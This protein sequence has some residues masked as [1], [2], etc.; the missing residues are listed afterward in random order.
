MTGSTERSS[1]LRGAWRQVHECS[2][3]RPVDSPVEEAEPQ[4]VWLAPPPPPT[5]D[6]CTAVDG[7]GGALEGWAGASEAA[8][9]RVHT[10]TCCAWR[11]AS[12]SQDSF[13]CACGGTRSWWWEQASCLWIGGRAAEGPL[14]AQESCQHVPASPGAWGADRGFC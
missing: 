6:N 11:R 13:L 4:C 7:E 14:C 5:R 12:W 3:V 8:A 1:G 2:F 10:N 9:L